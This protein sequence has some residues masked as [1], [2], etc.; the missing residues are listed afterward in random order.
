[1]QKYFKFSLKND[2]QVTLAFY[3]HMQEKIYFFYYL[4][5]IFLGFVCKNSFFLVIKLLK[6]SLVSVCQTHPQT[7]RSFNNNMA[8][9]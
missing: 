3:C 4:S 5:S 8:N 1:M 2:A 7:K 6:I 9:K